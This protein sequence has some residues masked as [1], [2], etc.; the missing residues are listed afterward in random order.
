MNVWITKYALT[1]GIYKIDGERS[2][3]QPNM[4]VRIKPSG[5]PPEYYHKP[6]WHERKA[7]ALR[8]ADSFRL[9]KIAS[10]KRVIAKLEGLKF[11]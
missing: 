5:G 3:S 2:E 4:F 8:H 1:Q 10:L 9:K 6:Y 7:D 11:R